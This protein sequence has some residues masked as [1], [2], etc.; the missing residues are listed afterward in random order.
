MSRICQL[1]GKKPMKGKKRSHSMNTTK[2]WFIP[3]IHTHRFWST[4][5]NK[6]YSIRT[7]TK[8]LRLINK[9]GFDQFLSNPIHKKIKS[10]KSI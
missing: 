9:I 6:F 3:N 5:K 1:T 2:R 8:G 4:N 10:I 7:S